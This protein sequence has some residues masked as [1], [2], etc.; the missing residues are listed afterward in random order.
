MKEFSKSNL[1]SRAIEIRPINELVGHLSEL[2][3]YLS[4]RELFVSIKDKFEL[5]PSFV[6]RINS[7]I[8]RPGGK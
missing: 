6:G 3:P 4:D 8:P 7:L 5:S 1:L 2:T